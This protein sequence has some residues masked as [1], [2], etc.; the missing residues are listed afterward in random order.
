[1]ARFKE[2]TENDSINAVQFGNDIVTDS[3]EIANEFNDLTT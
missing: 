1:V 3:Q 2:I